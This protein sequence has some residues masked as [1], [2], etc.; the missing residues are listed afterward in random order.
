MIGMPYLNYIQSKAKFSNYK[1]LDE[2]ICLEDEDLNLKF[3]QAKSFIAEKVIALKTG[4]IQNEFARVN[5][6]RVKI[7]IFYQI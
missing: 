2:K 4:K 5:I 6:T 3:I 1:C 7:N